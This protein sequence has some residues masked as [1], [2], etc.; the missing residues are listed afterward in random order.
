[1]SHE[2]RL[3][4][5]LS[6]ELGQIRKELAVLDRIMSTRNHLGKDEIK[7]RAAA[8]SLQSIYNGIEGMLRMVLKSQNIEQPHSIDSHSRLLGLASSNGI[9]SGKLENKLRELMTFRHFYRH[10]Y[11]F[12]IDD[13]LMDPLLMDVTG[14]VSRLAHELRIE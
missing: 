12:M 6:F 8:S 5:D 9:I 2:E 4:D 7:V 10:S 14:V 11:G 3:Q 13:E 1:V